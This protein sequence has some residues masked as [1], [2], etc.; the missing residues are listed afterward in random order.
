MLDYRG[1]EALYTVQEL[2]SF[3]A[4]AKKLHI[5]QSAV[6]QRIK[7]LETYYGEPVLIRT[8][9]YKPTKLGE[10]L[11]SHF[12]RMCLLEKSLEQ[13][14]A[15]TKKKPQISIALNR[16]SLETWFLDLIEQPN[17]FNNVTLEIIAD[18]QE[19][20]LDYL[21]KGLVS[22]CV[23]TSGK[24]VIGGNVTFLGN[25]EYLLVASPEFIKRYFS[26]KDKKKCLVNA[27]A[28]KFD[29]NDT[30]HERYL[31]KY[32]GLS[33]EDLQFHMMPSVRGF[34]KYVILGFGYGLIPKIDILE[35]LKSKKIIQLF[36]DQVWKI[37]L[38]WHYWDIESQYYKQFNLDIIHYAKNKLQLK[39]VT[40]HSAAELPFLA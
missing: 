2:Q 32:F 10:S 22:A 29:K 33:V 19:L 14:L 9:P 25:M 38:Y 4:A 7:G 11:I 35:E 17:I 15:Y 8:L 3:E 18:D 26:D 31:E 6:S 36:E 1:I 13:Q 21:R 39:P 5:T 16:D 27:P 20:T 24:G 34:K 40:G 30:L 28:I 23:S 12:K 37:P